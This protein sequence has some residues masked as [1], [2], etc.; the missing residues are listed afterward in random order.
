MKK[1]SLKHKLKELKNPSSKPIK[2]HGVM[3]TLISKEFIMMTVNT[4]LLKEEMSMLKK[5]TKKKLQLRLISTSK[6]VGIE[7]LELS[8]LNKSH[9]CFLNIQ[10]W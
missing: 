4:L 6:R 7:M 8:L 2:I 9:Q 1:K 3:L 10:E 5:K